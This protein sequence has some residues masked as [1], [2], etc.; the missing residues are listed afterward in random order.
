MLRVSLNETYE[1]VSF[2]KKLL[3]NAAQRRVQLHEVAKFHVLT[4]I[5]WRSQI[6]EYILKSQHLILFSE[7]CRPLLIKERAVSRFHPSRKVISVSMVMLC[8]WRR[9]PER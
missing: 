8:I 3:L 1:A 5:R 2:D 6:K 4:N 9:Q 7:Y